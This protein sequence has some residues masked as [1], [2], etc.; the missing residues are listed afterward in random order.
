M[1]RLLFIGMSLNV[2]GA[3]K[4]L[5]NLLNMI[6]C[7]KYSVSLLLFQKKGVL[8][9]QIPRDVNLV[10]IPEIKV[11]YQP[12]K[13][14][15][16]TETV[17]TK[18]IKLIVARYFGGIISRIKWKQFDQIRINR[19]M[20]YYSKLITQNA[21][22]YDVAIAYAGGECAYYMFDKVK[23]GKKIYY[24]HSDYSKIAIDVD[25]ERKY[26]DQADLIVTISEACKKSLITLFPEKAK[27]IVVLQNMSSPQLIKAMS[28]EYMPDEYKQSQS[29]FRIVS[30]GRLHEIK[31][32]DIA[33]EAAGILK[34]RGYNFCWVI[35]GEGDERKKLQK[36]IAE[37][38]LNDCFILAGLKEN[39]YPY[40]ANANVLLQT[41]RFEGKSVVLDEAR[42]LGI[43]AIVTNYNSAPDQI[44][45]GIDGIIVE[46]NPEAVAQGIERVITNP[47]ILSELAANISIDEKLCD[48][49]NYIKNML[50]E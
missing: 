21:E 19:W 10:E 48:I 14:S 42:I 32:F 12:A 8:L 13:D 26:V 44:N 4:S 49:D 46:M 29:P 45:D 38:G 23:A 5:V 43:P 7:N 47:E 2:G 1:K 16:K 25:L 33:I 30:V 20:K 31:G 9:K 6:D 41:S 39:P 11:L 3:E 34:K 35:V 50:M 28:Q 17:T 27:D 40:I 37:Y 24:F 18:M 15:I 36:M 22:I